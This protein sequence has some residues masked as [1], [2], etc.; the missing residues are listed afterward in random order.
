MHIS[1][2]EAY[3]IETLKGAGYTVEQAAQQI[4]T[5]DVTPFQQ[6]AKFDFQLLVNL[7][8]VERETFYAAFAGQYRVKFLTINGLKNL[9]K[10]KFGIENTRYTELE[11]GI[12]DLDVNEATE[13]AI[14]AF[15]SA[16]WN[17]ER[18]GEKLSITI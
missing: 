18:V 6:L 11:T 8:N 12:A 10:F 4:E 13:Q 3:I 5:G 15:V 9:L 7:Y 17:V 1:L 2:M 16:N 14:R